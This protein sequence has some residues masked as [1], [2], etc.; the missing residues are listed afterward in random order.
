M[1]RKRYGR[2]CEC[3]GKRSVKSVRTPLFKNALP[4]LLVDGQLGVTNELDEEE[5]VLL[6]I[7]LDRH[8]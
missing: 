1:D 5:L 3:L 8:G 7:P 6:G 4:D 2:L